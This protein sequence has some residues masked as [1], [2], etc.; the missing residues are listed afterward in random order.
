MMLMF[1]LGSPWQAKIRTHSLT[2]KKWLLLSLGILAVVSSTALAETPPVTFSIGS[3]RITINPPFGFCEASAATPYLSSY[4]AGLIT[5]QQFSLGGFLTNKEF[6]LASTG[7]EPALWHVAFAYSMERLRN[8]TLKAA[9]FAE[10]RTNYRENI[11]EAVQS[12]ADKTRE[13]VKKLGGTNE[14]VSSEGVFL[15]DASRAFS[16]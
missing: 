1:L 2:M 7:A 8:T 3:E 4:F 5:P 16:I 10:I 6:Q 12:S 14:F 13:A 15:D 11:K 9:D